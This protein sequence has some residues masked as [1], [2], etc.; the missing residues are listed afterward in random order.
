MSCEGEAGD[1]FYLILEGL[2]HVE[3]AGQGTVAKM[4]RGECFGEAALLTGT[5][6]NATVRAM[7]PVV[8]YSLPAPAFRRALE[9]SASM[10]QQLRK[11]MFQR[12]G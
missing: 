12:S 11:M 6:R 7:S 4:E 9:R 10:D 5:P 1:S 8:V 3:R 2:A